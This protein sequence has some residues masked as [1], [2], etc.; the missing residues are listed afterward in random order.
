MSIEERL[1]EDLKTAMRAKE[2]DRVACIRQLRSKV[3]EAVNAPDF[4]GPPD[5]ALY[6]KTIVSYAKSLEKGIAELMQAGE[7]SAPLRNKYSA[8]IAYLKQFLPQTMDAGAT[9]QLVVAAIEKLG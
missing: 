7:R 6:Q 4:K 8:E 1:N 2:A 9:R 3:Q 5:D